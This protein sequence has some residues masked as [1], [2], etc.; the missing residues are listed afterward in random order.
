MTVSIDG[1]APSTIAT[2]G[3]LLRWLNVT[4]DGRTV[5]F[6][7]LDDKAVKVFR[8][9]ITG[10]PATRLFAAQ[11]H[12]SSISPDGK[13][14][15]L[16]SGME[17]AGAK[18]AVISIDTGAPLPFPAVTGR[19]FRWTPD[20]KGISYLKHDGKQENI[21]IQPLAGGPSTPLT[22]FPEGSIANYEWSPDGQR[23]VLTHFLQTCDVVLLNPPTR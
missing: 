17:D 13:L 18:L 19:M 22:A 10:G 4:P 1:G 14:I 20:G 16:A 12:D 6:S 2:T 21:F 3:P 8:V 11:G 15:A 7:A 23:I 9:A 5:I